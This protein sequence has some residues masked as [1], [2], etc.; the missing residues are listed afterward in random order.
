[1]IGLGEMGANMTERLV[2]GGHRV[3]GHDL[4]PESVSQVVEKGAEGADWLRELAA[5]LPDP[6]IV[7]IMVP[8]GAPRDEEDYS[9]RIPAMRQKF[10]GHAVKREDG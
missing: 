10:G 5:K 6:Q 7:G 9:D 4:N 1:M 8:A 3:V 2:K